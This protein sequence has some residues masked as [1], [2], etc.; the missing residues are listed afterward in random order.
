M[1]L[2][3]HRHAVL[4]HILLLCLTAT[5]FEFKFKLLQVISIL[6]IIIQTHLKTAFFKDL[7]KFPKIYFFISIILTLGT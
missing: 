5:A 3:Y 4:N 1:A 6:G 2:Q 7:K